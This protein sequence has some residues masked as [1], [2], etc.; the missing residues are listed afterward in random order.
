MFGELKNFEETWKPIYKHFTFILTTR[1]GR[2]DHQRHPR[3][4]CLRSLLRCYFALW[5]CGRSEAWSPLVSNGGG[6]RTANQAIPKTQ[7]DQH[8]NDHHS[9]L[10]PG[11]L[12]RRQKALFPPHNPKTPPVS[13]QSTIFHHHNHNQ[14]RI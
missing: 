5:G 1:A 2:T 3:R 8:K 10:S 9:L 4:R 12:S 11:C 7:N 6:L 14:T 13:K